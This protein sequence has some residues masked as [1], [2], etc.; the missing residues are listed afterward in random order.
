[1]EF[2]FNKK[3]P[4]RKRTITAVEYRNKQRLTAVWEF[5]EDREGQAKAFE[6]VKE[7]HAIRHG[8]QTKLRI[9]D[10]TQGEE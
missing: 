5:P 9:G 2:K 3:R 6:K 7:A 8:R 1:M 4:G 10:D